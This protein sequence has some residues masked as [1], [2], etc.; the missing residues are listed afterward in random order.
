MFQKPSFKSTKEL[1]L[2]L[3]PAGAV[4]PWFGLRSEI[5]PGWILCDG[6][7]RT[8]NMSSASSSA[9]PG[10]RLRTG[11]GWAGRPCAELLHI[12][13]EDA[14]PKEQKEP[15]QGKGSPR[16]WRHEE[17]TWWEW[18]GSDGEEDPESETLEEDF[19]EQWP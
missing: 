19:E 5:P 11:S 15:S 8:P 17:W 6:Q 14:R 18:E 10:K 3:P 2:Q 7:H 13:R 16:E 12:M 1:E 4:L 9:A